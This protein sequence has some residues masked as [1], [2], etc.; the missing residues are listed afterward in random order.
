M[1]A[2]S[3]EELRQV[4]VLFAGSDDGQIASVDDVGANSAA[5]FD[6]PAEVGIH[7]GGATGEVDGGDLVDADEL[8]SPLEDLF[9]HYFVFAVGTGID[10]AVAAGLIA[11]FSE[12]EL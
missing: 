12:V 2:V 5:L 9:G 10:V 6:K 7:F 11:E 4:A 3:R 1:Q 8:E